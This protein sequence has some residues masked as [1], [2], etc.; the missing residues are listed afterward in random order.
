MTAD[1]FPHRWDISS[2]EAIALQQRLAGLVDT[3]HRLE[4]GQVTSVA[5]V[6]VSVRD[7]FSRAAIV[8]MRFPS[9]E[10]IE[11]AT[12]SMLTPFPYVPGLLSFREAPAILAA[13]EKLRT[14]PDFYIFDGMGIMHPRRLGIASHLGLWLDAPTLGCGKTYL[15]GDY[16]QPGLGRG[17]ASPVTDHGE[18]LGVALRTK[19]G[20]KPVFIS[21]G[22]RLDIDSAAALALACCTR[23]R[24]P[25]PIRAAHQLAAN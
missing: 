25:E 10:V 23:Y 2:Q 11:T 8:V 16:E 17:S 13:H 22:H 7:D 12:H 4:T 3:G 20:V 18:K 9:F 24:L 1:I 5:G 21:P 6:D 19:D 15:L 14:Y